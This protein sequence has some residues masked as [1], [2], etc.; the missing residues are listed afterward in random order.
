MIGHWELVIIVLVVVLLF[1][2]TKIPALMKGM[3]Q[4][5]SEFKAGLREG[6]K[7]PDEPKGPDGDKPASH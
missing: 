7:P 1:G 4:G 2:S 3:G 6:A 5:I